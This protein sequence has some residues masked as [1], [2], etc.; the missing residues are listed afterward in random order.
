MG[1]KEKG[2]LSLYPSH[3]P[4]R[5]DT[6]VSFRDRSVTAYKYN[7]KRRLGTS[8]GQGLLI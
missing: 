1:W 5:R 2:K 3:R 6:V 8:Q 4:F 7:D